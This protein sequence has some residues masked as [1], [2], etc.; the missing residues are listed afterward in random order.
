[1][2]THFPHGMKTQ[3]DRST[4]TIFIEVPHYCG[5]CE[6]ICFLACFKG[7][8][9]KL[10]IMLLTALIRESTQAEYAD[11]EQFYFSSITYY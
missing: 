1:M 11:I 3:D 4:G 6:F 5:L 9:A 2:A 8:G 10:V 7:I